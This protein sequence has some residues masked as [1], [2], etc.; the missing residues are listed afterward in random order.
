MKLLTVALKDLLH[1]L[2]SPFTLAMMFV[3][4]LLITGLLYFAFGGVMGGDGGFELAATRVQVVNLDRA[5]GVDGFAA[6][7]QLVSFLQQESLAGVLTVTLAEDET[8]ARAAV[9]AQEADIAVII[10]PAFS[11]TVLAPDAEASITFYQDPTKTIGPGI[12]KTLVAHNLDG[13]SGSQIAS[14]VT[15]KQLVSHGVPTGSDKEEQVAAQYGAWL[16]SGAHHDGATTVTPPVGQAAQASKSTT[17]LE[18]TMAGMMIF[19]VFFMGAHGAQSILRED[20]DGTLARL[21]TTPTAKATILGGKLVSVILALLVQIV[22]LLI[23]SFL[24]FDISWGAPLTLL[25]ATSGLIAAAAG[26]GVLLISF[27]DSTRQ[28]GPVLGGVLPL[29]GMLGG[30][31]TTGI[32]DLPAAFDT[33]MLFTPQGWALRS[34]ELALAGAAPHALFLPALVLLFGGFACFGAGVYRFSKRF[35]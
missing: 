23:V 9:V 25:L 2:R 3:A 34:W 32:P 11:A 19:F 12:V 30:L 4:P 6:G 10:P 27:I 29:M 35:A 13:F 8:S 7:E 24:I 14:R 22:V 5:D 17:V 26:F 16:Q 20:E 21:F 1:A 28:T 33:V 18:P 31:F 15:A